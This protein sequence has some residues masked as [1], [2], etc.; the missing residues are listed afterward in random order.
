M[1]RCLCFWSHGLLPAHKGCL[2]LMY[3]CTVDFYLLSLCPAVQGGSDFPG[4]RDVGSVSDRRARPPQR[5]TVSHCAELSGPDRTFQK[6]QRAKEVLSGAESRARYDL[7]RSSQVAMPFRQWEALAGVRAS[8]HWAVRGK[9]DLMLEEAG[10][11]QTKEIR[12]EGCSEREET[13][14]EELGSATERME[15]R[16]S[17][18]V[19]K[20]VLPQNPDSPGFSDVNSWRFRFRWSGDA[21]SELLRKFRNYE[22]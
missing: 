8:M 3:R 16:E 21:P 6:L 9:K 5:T 15:P 13:R 17:A 14:E 10:Q 19:E 12:N 11:T 22:I 2:L 1:C 4:G 20:S 18:S 7:W